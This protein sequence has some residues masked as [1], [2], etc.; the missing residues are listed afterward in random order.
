ML[1]IPPLPMHR[2]ENAKD[3]R[4]DSTTNIAY[5]YDVLME[6]CYFIYH[7][8][9]LIYFLY[10]QVYGSLNTCE[11]I[12]LLMAWFRIRKHTDVPNTM[13]TPVHRVMIQVF[14]GVCFGIIP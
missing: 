12:G 13:M 3:R 10:C 9:L 1:P 7:L 14:P 4:G 2:N 11:G 8:S 6:M 5:G